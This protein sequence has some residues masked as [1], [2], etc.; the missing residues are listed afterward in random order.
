M[1]GAGLTDAAADLCPTASGKWYLLR[2]ECAMKCASK[3]ALPDVWL[4]KHRTSKVLFG[5]KI[6]VVN[7]FPQAPYRPKVAVDVVIELVE[8]PSA[9]FMTAK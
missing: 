4:V 6:G 5:L 2:I 7:E 8:P 9:S 3:S 1:S